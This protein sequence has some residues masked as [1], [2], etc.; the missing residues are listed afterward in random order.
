MVSRLV[1]WSQPHAD[2]AKVCNDARRADQLAK[3][4]GD[5]RRDDERFMVLEASQTRQPRVA[6]ICLFGVDGATEA[7]KEKTSDGMGE[8]ALD[9]GRP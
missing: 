4:Q 5:G 2:G 9:V 8:V 3:T 7:K 1:A 6:M